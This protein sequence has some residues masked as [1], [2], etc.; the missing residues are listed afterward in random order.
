MP[1]W[2][3]VWTDLDVQLRQINNRDAQLISTGQR[4]CPYMYVMNRIYSGD[5]YIHMHQ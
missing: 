3:G 2:L 4:L 5:K 1:R